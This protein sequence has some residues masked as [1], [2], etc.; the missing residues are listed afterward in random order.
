MK[1]TLKYLYVILSFCFIL[2]INVQAAT[3]NINDNL[4]GG[5]T[6]NISSTITNNYGQATTDDLFLD[7]KS[8]EDQ[9]IAPDSKNTS[10]GYFANITYYCNIALKDSIKIDDK[11]AYMA[12]GLTY[13]FTKTYEKAKQL[14][15]FV[16][17]HITYDMT[18]YNQIKTKSNLCSINAGAQIGFDTASGVCFEYATLYAAMANAAGINVRLIYTPGHIWNMIY[19][20]ETKKWVAIDCTWKLFDFDVSKYHESYTIHAEF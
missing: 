5:N 4:Q 6:Y 20:M 10:N 9:L 3:V 15:N 12:K 13:N 2:L 11:A 19:D 1:N 8:D 7:A 14:Y 18:K 16:S 17:K